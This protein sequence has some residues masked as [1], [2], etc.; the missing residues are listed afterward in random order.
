MAV[1]MIFERTAVFFLSRRDKD[2]DVTMVIYDCSHIIL[3]SQ[4]AEFGR[5]EL[6][7]L[8][9][10]VCVNRIDFCGWVMNANREIHPAHPAGWS[11]VGVP[12][13]G[14]TARG[15]SDRMQRSLSRHRETVRV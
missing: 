13:G 9:G 7:D 3:G 14:F 10:K 1:A 15:G 6:A 4:G 12:G 8:K 2:C 11:R 5:L